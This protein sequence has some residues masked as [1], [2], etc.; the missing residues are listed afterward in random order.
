[1]RRSGFTPKTSWKRIERSG[2]MRAVGKKGQLWI[3][4]RKQIKQR[5]EWAGIT[6]CE[7]RFQ[8]CYYDASGGFAHCRK[9]R[10]LLEGEIW[11]V[12]LACLHCHTCL[13][14]KMSHEDMHNEVHKVIE[15]RGGILAPPAILQQIQ[16]SQN[17]N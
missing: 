5:F 7:F 14:E 13:D 11:H 3:N 2:R 6:I 8:G 12:G 17:R 4:V 16:G 10:N 15:K 1:M 9:R